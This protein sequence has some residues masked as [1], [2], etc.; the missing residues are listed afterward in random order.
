MNEVE[1]MEKRTLVKPKVLLESA[2]EIVPADCTP[3]ILRVHG[4]LFLAS[5]PCAVKIQIARFFPCFGCN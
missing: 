5:T 3:Y 2:V 1:I 4:P